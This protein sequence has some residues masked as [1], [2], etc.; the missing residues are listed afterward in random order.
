MRGRLEGSSRSGGP[1]R[2]M[3]RVRHR[4]TDLEVGGADSMLQKL[5]SVNEGGSHDLVVF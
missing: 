3:T 1:Q 2:D 5:V 4:I